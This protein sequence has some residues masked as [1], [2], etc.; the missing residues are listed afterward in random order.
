MAAARKKW[1]GRKQTK[2][3][4]ILLRFRLVIDFPLFK[5]TKK[6]KEKNI[7]KNTKHG[8]DK[9]KKFIIHFL[10]T[11]TNVSSFNSDIITANALLMKLLFQNN[12]CYSLL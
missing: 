8:H 5:N 10:K 11:V 9:E 7:S 6:K 12:I 3:G 1:Q 2:V 4:L